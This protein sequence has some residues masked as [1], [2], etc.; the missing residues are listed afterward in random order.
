MLSSN[1]WRFC[2]MALCLGEI[3]AK[4]LRRGPTIN[5]M[6][7]KTFGLLKHPVSAKIMNFLTPPPTPTVTDPDFELRVEGRGREGE[8]TRF[9]LPPATGFSS[10]CIFSFSKLGARG[11]GLPPLD[12]PTGLYVLTPYSRLTAWCDSWWKL[13]EVLVC[14][15]FDP[16]Y[17][18][19]PIGPCDY[20]T[21][22]YLTTK[23][24]HSVSNT[25]LS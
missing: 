3:E 2:F 22:Y 18:K 14:R 24:S 16:G 11:G 19:T 13:A 9:V 5:G 12:P 21:R 4:I 23:T 6:C 15:Y 1:N 20:W 8:R 10:F 17:R 7:D 25:R